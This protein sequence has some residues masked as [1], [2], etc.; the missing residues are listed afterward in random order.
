MRGDERTGCDARR[1]SLMR[2]R[3]LVGAVQ[4]SERNEPHQYLAELITGLHA[5]GVD[6]QTA[7]VHDGPARRDLEAGAEVRVV[8]RLRPRSPSGLA[9][10]L[11]LRVSAERAEQVRTW[12]TRRAGATVRGRRGVGPGRRRWLQRP[13]CVHLN[14]PQAVPVLRYRETEGVPVTTY[15]HPAHLGIEGLAPADRALLLDRTDRFL[16]ADEATASELVSA[17]AEECRVELAPHPLVFP[18]P[19]VP[20]P[21]RAAS[22]SALGLPAASVVLGAPPVP[23]WIDAP[24]LTLALAWELER[25][26]GQ[27]APRVLWYEMPT[28][29]RRRWPVENDR[30]R[31][32]LHSVQ[33]VDQLPDSVDLLDLVDLVVLPT[34][35]TAPVP[36]L[37]VT[38]AAA[39]GTPVLCWQGH[40][41][42]DEVAGW[43]AGVVDPPDVSAM[44]AQVLRLLDDPARRRALG[45]SGRVTTMERI[46]RLT[47]LGMP[48]P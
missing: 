6:I 43:T 37:F 10:S 3:V 34:H 46:E 42:A 44:A 11:A 7:L 33:V 48:V 25:Q 8:P 30:E 27:D 36:E 5:M 16:A 24:D 21:T 29:E 4:A 26:R 18:A 20:E 47:P 12:R 19:L 31:M 28:D 15:V 2:H 13:D 32:G 17:G 9:Q 45:R 38:W 22:R 14:G 41:L 35:S 40:P 23:D 39:H 1:E